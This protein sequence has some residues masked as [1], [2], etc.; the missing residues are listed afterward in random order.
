MKRLT[1]LRYLIILYIIQSLYFLPL[2]ICQTETIENK[3]I[4]SIVIIGNEITEENVIRREL[5]VNEGDI[6]T[7]EQL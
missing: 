1:N 6:P 7:K 4:L 5:L 3:P 2:A